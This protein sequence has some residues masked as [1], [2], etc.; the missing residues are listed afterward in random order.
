MNVH[1]NMF[2]ILYSLKIKKKDLLHQ[3]FEIK[4]PKFSYKKKK[5]VP[6]NLEADSKKAE[7][8][9]SVKTQIQEIGSWKRQQ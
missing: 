3:K 9:F 8:R 4:N 2:N 5:S 1:V 7:E 6:G